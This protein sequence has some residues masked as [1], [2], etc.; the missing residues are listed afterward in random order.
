M[1]LVA[2]WHGAKPVLLRANAGKD[3][4]IVAIVQ[5]NVLVH[6]NRCDGTW[7]RVEAKGRRGY[8]RQTKLWGAYPDEKF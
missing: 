3:A 1:A 6:V 2:P 8:I 5:P 4:S 7:C